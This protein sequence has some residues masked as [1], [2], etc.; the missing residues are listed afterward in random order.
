VGAPAHTVWP[1]QPQLSAAG[2]EFDDD[3]DDDVGVGDEC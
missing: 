2:D 1:G 3:D